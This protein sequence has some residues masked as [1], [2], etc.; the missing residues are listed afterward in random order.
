MFAVL[1]ILACLPQV[2][3]AREVLRD[4][5]LPRGFKGWAAARAD[6]A[7]LSAT[8]MGLPATSLQ[9]G[10][11]FCL[12][13]MLDAS[14]AQGVSGRLPLHA[15]S[16][17]PHGLAAL[18]GGETTPAIRLVGVDRP[19]TATPPVSSIAQTMCTPVLRNR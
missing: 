5:D 12:G 4:A 9:S 1:C 6:D 13:A 2:T 3:H 14:M 19:T 18:R 7:V 17:C 10:A 8:A 11:D 16:Y 15:L